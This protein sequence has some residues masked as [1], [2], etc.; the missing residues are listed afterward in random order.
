MSFERI[1]IELT[2]VCNKGCSFCYN[3][4]GRDG[5]TLWTAD[6]VVAFALDCARHGTRAVSL[7][8]GEPLM[9]E[10]LWEVL[11]GLR[12]QVFRSLTT[13]GLLLT[14]SDV[15]ARLV[16]AAPDKVH[17]S[18]HQPGVKAEVRHVIGIVRGLHEAG[19]ASG[20]NLLV[21]ALNPASAAEAA[22]SLHAAG[23]DNRRIVYLPER[24]GATSPTAREVA[25]VA[26]GPFQSMS[27][28]REC[29]PSPRFCSISWDRQAAWC[30]YTATRR[31]LASP[32]YASLRDALEGLGL[33]YCGSRSR[34]TW[35][36]S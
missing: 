27:C 7:G 31:P 33:A 28:L 6:E 35:M 22:A 21:P 32:T 19:I 15:F 8:G 2:N 10:G 29:G 11:A 12:G 25:D 1:S 17:V 4:S 24:G 9:F 5:Q 3:Q 23:I 14:Q 30:S 34:V 20:V 18:I 26:G 13:N 36:N 16:A